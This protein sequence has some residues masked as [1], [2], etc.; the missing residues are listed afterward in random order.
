[1]VE[2][3]S[4]NVRAENRTRPRREFVDAVRDIANARFQP[5]FED[6]RDS[7]NVVPED[8]RRIA[9]A[10][11]EQVRDPSVAGVV[12]A[13]GT[14]TLAY[15]ASAVAY[16]LGKNLTKPV[17]FTGSQATLKVH[18]G[19]AVINL[20]RACK[21]AADAGGRLPEVVV[22]FGDTVLRACQ[23]QKR[24]DR[25]FDAFES[26]L[27]PPL[28]IL[29]EEIEYNSRVI[30]AHHDPPP[31]IDIRADFDSHILS[32][33]QVPG[34]RPSLYEPVL[35]SERVSGIIVQSL[36]AGNLPTQKD[37]SLVSFIERAVAM[38]IPVVLGS[39]YPVLSSNPSKYAPAQ[40]AHKAGALPAFNVTLPA[41]VTKFAWILGRL[42]DDNAKRD[43]VSGSR[44]D[45]VQ[46]WINTNLV[47]EIATDNEDLTIARHEG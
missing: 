11:H 39:L 27:S 34:L 47:S 35:A 5:V 30:Q 29:T 18:H 46:S 42:L 3:E 40:E 31:P 2:D 41:L 22:C 25:R 12:V 38:D 45:F 43:H 33:A 16:A 6:P 4:G 9:L 37:Y 8:W 32:I 14:D 17:V 1:M 20:Q 24:D 15:T 13:H 10:V 28:A 21:L 7:A 26:P 23:A 36:G 19:D 44:R